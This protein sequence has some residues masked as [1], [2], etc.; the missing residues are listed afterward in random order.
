MP[1]LTALAPPYRI[2]KLF[3]TLNLKFTFLSFF[4]LSQY[5][6]MNKCAYVYI[7]ILPHENTWNSNR[8]IYNTGEAH[9]SNVTADIARGWF[10]NI[11]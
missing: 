1:Y 6:P 3:C 9:L 4:T 7:P 5:S 2:V 11:N 8:E 10:I